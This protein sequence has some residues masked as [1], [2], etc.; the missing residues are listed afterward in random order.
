M[1]AG[2]GLTFSAL[3]GAARTWGWF[4][5]VPRIQTL[6]QPVVPSIE[7]KLLRDHIQGPATSARCLGLPPWS[8]NHTP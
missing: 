2:W 8:D 3:Q 1:R 5:S 7:H 6:R 4:M